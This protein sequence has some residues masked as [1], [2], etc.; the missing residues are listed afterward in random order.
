MG[1]ANIYAVFGRVDLLTRLI[2]ILTNL[3]V[4]TVKRQR[5]KYFSE[6]PVVIYYKGK[7]MKRH[8]PNYYTT[9]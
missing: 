4:V 2:K 9:K 3:L 8:R 5:V 7:E 1:E 6:N